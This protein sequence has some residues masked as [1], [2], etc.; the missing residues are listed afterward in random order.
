MSNSDNP[1]KGK[2]F[3]HKIR[4]ILTREYKI[5]F[6]E[7]VSFP[8]GFPSK[9]HRFDCVSL[10]KK[11]VV[12]CK[13]YSWT[14]SSNS[15][16]AKFSTLNE[17]VLYFSY[18]PNTIEKIIAMKKSINSKRQLSLAQHYVNSNYELLSDIK[19]LEYDEENNT[20]SWIF[21]QSY[22]LVIEYE[23]KKHL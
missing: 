21:P 1:I 15:P 6:K 2:E 12:E 8:I 18:L 9:E 10:D 20:F 19:V 3:Q 7:E 17:A 23:N 14:E 13:C 4:N 22:W 11:I 16:S 5:D